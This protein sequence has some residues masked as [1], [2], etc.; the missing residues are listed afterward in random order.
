M[1]EVPPITLYV[2][3]SI[4]LILLKTFLRMSS[5]KSIVKGKDVKKKEKECC[6]TWIS[7]I[8]SV[9]RILFLMRK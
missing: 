2:T 6:L 9:R 5:L 8:N 1:T 4:Q 7:L 3:G